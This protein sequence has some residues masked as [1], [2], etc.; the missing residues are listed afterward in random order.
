MAT[1]S[2]EPEITSDFPLPPKY[3]NN[4]I[5]SGLDPPKPPTDGVFVVFGEQRKLNEVTPTL[6]DQDLITLY[7]P[8][9]KRKDEVKKLVG[10]AQD[11][12]LDLV[13]SLSENASQIVL[14]QKVKDLDMCFINMIYLVNE[15]RSE[16]AKSTIKALLEKQ[17]QAKK[18]SIKLLAE[19]REKSKADIKQAVVNMAQ[20]KVQMDVSMLDVS[21]GQ[22]N[23]STM[24]TRNIE[25]IVDEAIKRF[26]GID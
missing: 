13:T 14:D 3:Y 22:Q 9:A 1:S 19:A 2:D 23:T 16:Q 20:R 26:K 17:I 15:L 12:F 4:K 6:E 21:N 18:D 25:A 11:R 24:A 7:D 10:L 5:G 8:K